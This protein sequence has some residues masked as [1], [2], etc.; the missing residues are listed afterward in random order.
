MKQFVVVGLGRFGTSVATSL[1]EEGY[2]VLAIDK[3]EDLVQEITDKVTHAVQADATDEDS[4]KTLGVNNF[5]V[6]VVSIGDDI[7]SSL[8]ATLILKELGVEYVVVKAQT[9]LHGKVLNKIGADKIV[10]PERDMGVRVA[11]NLVTTNVLDY[12]ELSPNYS[13]IEVLATDKL[14][15]KTLRELELRAKF[16][17][18]V[19][20]IK[21]EENEI[22]VTP[23]ADDM[24]ESGDVLVVMGQEK[25]LD[26]LR[27][28]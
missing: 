4:L 6:A 25:D 27:E 11:Y 7:Q 10:Y 15:G 1:A 12:I 8:L 23:E 17:I 16:G 19:I 28:Y 21:K 2:D 13:I 20:A 18:N 9:K 14:T 3:E 5:D 24:V 26:K 22:N